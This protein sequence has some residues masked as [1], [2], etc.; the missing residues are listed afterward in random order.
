MGLAGNWMNLLMEERADFYQEKWMTETKLLL[1][2]YPESS[3]VIVVLI[4]FIIDC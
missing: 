1:F 2:K 4:C 3:W